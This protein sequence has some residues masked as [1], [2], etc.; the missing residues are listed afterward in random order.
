MS[1]RPAQVVLAL[2]VRF[3]NV[4]LVA[5]ELAMKIVTRGRRSVGLA[6]AVLALVLGLPAVLW[7]DEPVLGKDGPVSEGGAGESGQIES[8]D[9]E[10]GA[11]KDRADEE[12][13]GRRWCRHYYYPAHH[14][15]P[16]YYFPVVSY[17]VVTYPVV[18]YPVVSYPTVTVRGYGAYAVFFDGKSGSTDGQA[19]ASDKVTDGLN[20]PSD[21]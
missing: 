13:R 11:P 2:G 8:T 21:F 6:G 19:A 14:Y 20:K 3:N 10:L 15:Q 9:G 7:A 4:N 18:S 5:K 17:S 12:D 16:V 1:Q